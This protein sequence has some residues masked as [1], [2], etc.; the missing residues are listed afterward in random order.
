MSDITCALHVNGNKIAYT[1]FVVLFCMSFTGQSLIQRRIIKDLSRPRN[2]RKN[3][4]FK[5]RKTK[6]LVSGVLRR[7]CKSMKKS[8]KENESKTFVPNP[9][10]ILIQFR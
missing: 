10:P 1:A 9:R 7:V 5:K 3:R 4:G 8:T 2:M 6:M